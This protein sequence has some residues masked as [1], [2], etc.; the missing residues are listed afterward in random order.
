MPLA[1][2]FGFP[3]WARP[4]LCPTPIS[5]AAIRTTRPVLY[6]APAFIMLVLLAALYWGTGSSS[7]N[8]AFTLRP[9]ALRGTSD[10]ASMTTPGGAGTPPKHCN[11]L[12]A[13]RAGF[14]HRVGACCPTWLR[15]FA[16]LRSYAAGCFLC[17]GQCG[18]HKKPNIRRCEHPLA[19]GPGPIG[20]GLCAIHPSSWNGHSAKFAYTE[21]CEVREESCKKYCN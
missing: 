11:L 9:S 19:G 18:V 15:L 5:H 16:L 17:T 10:G 4:T 7:T 2:L 6:G 14:H 13:R 12:R 1:A 20:A 3:P 21:Y 8:A